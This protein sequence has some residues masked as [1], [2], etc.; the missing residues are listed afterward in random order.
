MTLLDILK[1]EVHL[2]ALRLRADLYLSPE[3]GLRILVVS[4]LNAEKAKAQTRFWVVLI[5]L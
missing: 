2:R 3:R 5:F 1:G 4:P